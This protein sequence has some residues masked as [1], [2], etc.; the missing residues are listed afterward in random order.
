MRD[1][2]V[3]TNGFHS[4]TTQL[5]LEMIKDYHSTYVHE[6]GKLYLQNQYFMA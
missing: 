2:N 3:A 4:D 5:F 6:L 1:S